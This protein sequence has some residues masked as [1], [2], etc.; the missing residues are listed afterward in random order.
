MKQCSLNHFQ[1]LHSSL[2]EIVSDSDR[3]IDVRCSHT[4]FSSLVLVF[5]SSKVGCFH[6]YCHVVHVSLVEVNQAI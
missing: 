6:E 1:L 4:I 5:N 3:M 2:C